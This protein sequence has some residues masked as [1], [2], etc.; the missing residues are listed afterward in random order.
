M[1]VCALRSE[2]FKVSVFFW[3]WG[4]DEAVVLIGRKAGRGNKRLE[5]VRRPRDFLWRGILFSFSVFFNLFFL[6]VHDPAERSA[7]D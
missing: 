1:D 2:V 4:V 5:V 6:N 3:L 7:L